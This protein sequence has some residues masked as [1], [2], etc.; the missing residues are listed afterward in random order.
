MYVEVN[1]TYKGIS[2]LVYSVENNVNVF[3][4]RYFKAKFG[5]I[6]QH[7]INET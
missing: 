2:H 5:V 4:N 3:G 7:V 1:T 6:G